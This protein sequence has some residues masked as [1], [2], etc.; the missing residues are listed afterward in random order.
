MKIKRVIAGIIVAGSLFLVGLNAA[1]AYNPR[2]SPGAFI[3]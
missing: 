3:H 1:Q 2:S